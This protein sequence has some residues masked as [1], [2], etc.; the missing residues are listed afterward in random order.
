MIIQRV[1]PGDV[2]MVGGVDGL[3]PVM[4]IAVSDVDITLLS[5]KGYVYYAPSEDQTVDLFIDD[6]Y[7][8]YESLSS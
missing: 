1:K 7:I 5:S 6:I 2:L 3:V 4:I 8:P